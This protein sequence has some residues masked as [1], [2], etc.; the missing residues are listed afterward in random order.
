MSLSSDARIAWGLKEEGDELFARGDFGGAIE[1]YTKALGL[2][3]RDPDLWNVK[4]LALSKLKRYDEAIKSYDVALEHYPR[5]T[6]VWNNKGVA[7]DNAGK[8]IEAIRCFDTVID[9]DP[10]DAGAWCN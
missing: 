4:G 10:Q 7:L 2:F 9:I 1:C 8:H 5:E 3:P 6:V